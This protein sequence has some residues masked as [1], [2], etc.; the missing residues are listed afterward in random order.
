[1]RPALPFIAALLLL[2]CASA[3]ESQAV[4]V[5]AVADN[6]FTLDG[7][8]FQ[9]I[10]GAI[11]YPRIPRAYWRDRLKAARAM[12]LNTV[13]TYAFWNVH[14]PV[15]GH[16]D[17]SGQNDI[18][19]FIREAQQEG[20]Y[21]ILRPG[22]YVCAEW[23]WGGFPSWLNADPKMVVRSSYPGFINASKSY[24]DELGKQTASLQVGNGGPILAVQVENEYGSFGEDHAYM[25]QI[26]QAVL[27]AG[28]TKSLLYTADGP[29]VLAKG[30]LPD[31]PIGVN[32][33]EGDA[34]RAFSLY[35]KFRPGSIHFN[36]EYW[37]GWFDHWGAKHETRDTA[38]EAAELKSMLERGDSVNLYMFAGG[39][40]FGWMNGANS[41]APNADGTTMKNANYEPDVTSYDYDVPVSESGTLQPKYFAFRKVIQAVTGETLPEP[42]LAPKAVPVG[43]LTLTRGA[44]LWKNL[45]KPVHSS[46]PL[47]ME[48]LGQ[49]YGYVLYRTRLSG[50]SLPGERQLKL[51]ILHDYA[52]VYVDGM[53]QGAVDRRLSQTTLVI[54]TSKPNAQL[55]ILVENTG[56]VNYG[57]ALSGERVGL[58]ASPILDGKEL[59]GWDSFRLP[60]ATSNQLSF[61]AG[62][63]EGPCLYQSTFTVNNP[64]DTFLDTSSLSKGFVW[65]NGIPLGRFWSVGPQK[66]LYLPGPWLHAG[67]NEIQVFD[68]A[69]KGKPTIKGTTTH[70]LDSQPVEDPLTVGSH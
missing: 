36:S 9:V 11:H 41:N 7:K 4:H 58:L 50:R 3:I 30:S 17:F 68:L 10:S 44:S 47:T 51:P 42:P 45:P 1:M 35:D 63:C 64:G 49:S 29:D 6:H 28:F 22:P 65:V 27:H 14:E 21:V 37:D 8:P 46:A 15:Q 53:F 69:G 19:E 55:D 62:P 24:L 33:G 23:E 32:F 40:S 5:F 70:V 52:L 60:M 61:S 66:T 54:H 56:R 57:K 13:E 39:T 25:E 31:L 2:P 67:Q 38:K 26:H 48:A 20:L 59:K 18:A 12:G 43:P 34:Q 16:F